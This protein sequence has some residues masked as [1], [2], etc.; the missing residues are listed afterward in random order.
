MAGFFE[1]LDLIRNK[2]A[3]LNRIIEK[4]DSQNKELLNII[5]DL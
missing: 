2:E 1:N 4:K 5:T 3:N